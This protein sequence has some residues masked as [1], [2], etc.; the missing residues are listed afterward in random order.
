MKKAG[1]R[2]KSVLI[3]RQSA[4]T[5]SILSPP[6][7]YVENEDGTFTYMEDAALYEEDLLDNA[8]E[9]EITGIVRPKEDAQNAKISTAVGYT[10]KLTDYLISHTDES[11]VIQAQEADNTV[12][13]LTGMEFEAPDDEAKAEDAKAYLSDLGVSEK[14]TFYQPDAVLSVKQFETGRRS[15]RAAAG[16]AATGQAGMASGSM[17]MDETTMAAALDQWLGQ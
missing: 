16:Q 2:K 12:N 4:A 17:A 6:D 5:P 13:V 1:K 14:A 15:R 10:S 9:L 11:A 3:T 7:H 8:L